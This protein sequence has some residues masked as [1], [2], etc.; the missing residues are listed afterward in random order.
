MTT[1]P[2]ATVF[3]R[4]LRGNGAFHMT[5]DPSGSNGNMLFVADA[6]V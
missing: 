3:A 1:S 6:L 5:L 4:N 2:G